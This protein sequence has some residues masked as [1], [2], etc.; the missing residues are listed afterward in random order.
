VQSMSVTRTPGQ[1]QMRFVLRVEATETDANAA[2][3]RVTDVLSR[4]GFKT[5]DFKTNQVPNGFEYDHL[6]NVPAND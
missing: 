2:F 3:N 1:P 6:L 4:M 5:I